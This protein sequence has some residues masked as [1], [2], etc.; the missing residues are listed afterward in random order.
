[1]PMISSSLPSAIFVLLLM[2]SAVSGTQ[3]D[4]R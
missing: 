4:H 2:I 1:M 3:E